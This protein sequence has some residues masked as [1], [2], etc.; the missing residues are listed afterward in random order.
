[1]RRCNVPQLLV[2]RATHC[3]PHVGSLAGTPCVSH[4]L[5]TI[6][7]RSPRNLI[8]TSHRLQVVL[9]PGIVPQ[10]QPL[11]APSLCLALSLQG[12]FELPAVELLL[13]ILPVSAC[14]LQMHPIPT[15]LCL[16]APR[17]ACY[18][19]QRKAAGLGPNCHSLCLCRNSDRHGFIVR[20]ETSHSAP[21]I[22]VRLGPCEQLSKWPFRAG[23][24]KPISRKTQPLEV[25]GPAVKIR[26]ESR[27]VRQEV[28]VTPPMR[29]PLRVSHLAPFP[30]IQRF[31][32]SSHMRGMLKVVED[33]PSDPGT[34]RYM[35]SCPLIAPKAGGKS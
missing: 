7:D 22:P 31:A 24:E 19:I 13:S 29:M 12:R 9:P 20:Y 30:M 8:S 3:R 11:E 17:Q 5:C 2:K 4:E 1:M 32:L 14:P 15:C 10:P 6:P 16:E 28:H 27:M 34:L 35:G 23:G 26:I 25:F 21:N 33:I 18:G